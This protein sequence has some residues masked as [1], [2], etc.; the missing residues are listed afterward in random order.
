MDRGGEEGTYL[1]TSKFFN[2]AGVWQMSDLRDKLIFHFARY[3][4]MSR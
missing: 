2:L 3:F 1:W 4:K